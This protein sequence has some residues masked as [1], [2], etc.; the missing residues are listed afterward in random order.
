MA[1]RGNIRSSYALG[2][3]LVFGIEVIAYSSSA[4][5]R[6]GVLSVDGA[7]VLTLTFLCKGDSISLLVDNAS[8]KLEIV[9]SY[10]LFTLFS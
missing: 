9:C 7:K 1:N 8:I 10:K 6:S 5:S 3:I 2:D 4:T